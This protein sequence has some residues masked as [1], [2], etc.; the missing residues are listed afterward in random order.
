MARAGRQFGAVESQ[1]EHL[2]SQAE[3]SRRLAMMAD[4]STRETLLALAIEFDEKAEQLASQA[5]P[6]GLPRP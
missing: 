1:L 6:D 2:R 4:P 5:K 3:R